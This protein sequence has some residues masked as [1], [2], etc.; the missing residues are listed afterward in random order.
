VIQ[1]KDKLAEEKRSLEESHKGYFSEEDEAA[2]TAPLDRPCL[3]D[4]IGILETNLVGAV[5][6]RFNNVTA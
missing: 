1:A 3:L 6:H 2:D 5:E 4:K